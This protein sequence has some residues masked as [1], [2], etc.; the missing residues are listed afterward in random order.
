MRS[1]LLLALLAACASN[2]KKLTT[3]ESRTAKLEERT[4]AL[5]SP[6]KPEP[7]PEPQ[8][9]PEPEPISS[10]PVSE[11]S[12]RMRA[13]IRKFADDVCNCPDQACLSA[14]QQEFETGY[15]LLG[16]FNPTDEDA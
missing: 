9:E 10:G 12:A 16:R 2:D 1:W 11:Q 3:L 15:R 13:I 4:T 6:A 14:A 7:E 5:E 8:P